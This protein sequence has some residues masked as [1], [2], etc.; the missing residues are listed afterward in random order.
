MSRTFTHG[1]VPG[2][3]DSPPSGAIAAI[4]IRPIARPSWIL[5][6]ALGATLAMAAPAGALVRSVSMVTTGDMSGNVEYNGGGAIFD[7][8]SPDFRRIIFTSPQHYAGNDDESGSEDIFVHENGKNRIVSVGP[9]TEPGVG[10]A[11]NVDFEAASADA[12]RVLWSTDDDITPEDDDRDHTTDTARDLYLREGDRTELVSVGPGDDSA[13][14]GGA[15]TD[16]RRIFFTTSNPLVAEDRDDGVDLYLRAGGTTTLISRPPEGTPEPDHRGAYDP[17]VSADGRRV[18]FTSYRRLTTSDTDDHKDGFEWSGGKLRQ[19]TLGPSGGN[20]PIDAGTGEVFEERAI[21]AI[22]RSGDRAWF[23][24]DERLTPDDRDDRMDLYERAGGKTR[25]VSIGPAGG[26]GQFDVG[27]PFEDQRE[28]DP[29]HY[30]R[31]EKFSDD[32]RTVFF[33]TFE[34]LTKEDRDDFYDVYRRRGGKTTIV[35]P[36]GRGKVSYT[37]ISLRG[38]SPDGRRG[39]LHTRERLTRDDKDDSTDLYSWTDGGGVR[40]LS[41]GPRGGNRDEA[42]IFDF[43]RVFRPTDVFPSVVTRD[44]RSAFFSTYERL[45]SD[46]KDKTRSIYETR[47]G[48][49]SLARLRLKSGKVVNMYSEPEHDGITR[50]GR[51]FVFLTDAAYASGDTDD[52]N[53]DLYLARLR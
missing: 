14:F 50:D 52:T 34:R 31:L 17:L 42:F 2:S 22:T 1:S 13:G 27:A 15:S 12:R 21:E 38:I 36:P 39:I 33:G 4:T 23:F 10:Y 20:G 41:V 8:A 3:L 11:Q 7:A 16:L 49:L 35:A 6:A 19:V 26:N 43:P 51:D 46:D 37:G 5:L 25:L 28:E 29:F 48:S 9:I 45:T 30:G 47:S 53:A 44:G 18:F 24:S 32:G 40:R